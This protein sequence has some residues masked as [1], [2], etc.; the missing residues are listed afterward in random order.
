MSIQL[1]EPLNKNNNSAEE[2]FGCRTKYSTGVAIYKLVNEIQETLHNNNL[3]GGIFCDIEKAFDCVNHEVLLSKLEFC[4]IKGKAKLWFESYFRNRYQ[5]VLITNTSLNSNESSIWGKIRHGVPQGS[6]LRPL[7]FVLYIN[8][9]PKII[10]DKT[11]PILFA[12]DTSLLV[13]SS[14]HEELCANT[15]TAF[16]SINDWFKVNQLS[17]NFNKTHYIQF[18]ARNNN[19]ENKINIAYDNKQIT[20]IS[21]IKVLAIYFDDKISWKYHIEHISSKLSAACFIIR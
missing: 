19:M 12:D 5:R 21:N 16:C 7:L 18:T 11:I 3:I 17:I 15:N 20:S 13:T 14:T 9:L 4:G 2:Q 1:L 8:D 10:N 6:I